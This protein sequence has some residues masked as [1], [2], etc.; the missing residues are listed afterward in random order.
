MNRSIT[1]STDSVHLGILSSTAS[2]GVDHLEAYLGNI[3]QDTLVGENPAM[4][5]IFLNQFI[6]VDG[7]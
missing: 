3:G 5:S 6:K 2:V 4:V 1:K 7:N